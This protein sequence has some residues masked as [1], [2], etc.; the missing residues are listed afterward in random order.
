MRRPWRFDWISGVSLHPRPPRW[1]KTWAYFVT[2]KDPSVDWSGALAQTVR[3]SCQ[4][5]APTRS[6]GPLNNRSAGDRIINKSSARCVWHLPSANITVSAK[7]P[8]L[9]HVRHGKG[10][11]LLSSEERN[12]HFPHPARGFDL[13]QRP[14]ASRSSC[15]PKVRRCRIRSSVIQRGSRDY[16]VWVWQWHVQPSSSDLAS[17][18]ASKLASYFYS[19]WQNAA[20]NPS[21]GPSHLKSLPR[22]PLV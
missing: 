21:T 9:L 7:L 18:W 16:R 8:L 4:F 15:L 19:I 12:R 20:R 17:Q 10:S 13:T 3:N 14:N 2:E 6:V 11:Y 5:V 22:K 1:L